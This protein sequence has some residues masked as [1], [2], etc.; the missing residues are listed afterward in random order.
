MALKTVPTGTVQASIGRRF[1]GKTL[2]DV[3]NEIELCGEPG[4]TN[5]VLTWI[6][7]EKLEGQI[8]LDLI[9]KVTMEMPFWINYSS[10]PKAE[11]DEWDRFYKALRY[12]E[13]AHH[14][15]AKREANTMYLTLRKEKTVANLRSVFQR[16]LNR[17]QRS[18]DAFDLKVDHGRKQTSPYG[19]TIIT[20]PKQSRT[21]SE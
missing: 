7:D 21:E 11:K 4:K 14:A 18:S 2:A 1:N 20:I 12:H 6:P 19:N 9:L 16:E 13:D 5:W 3:T 17:I 10:R 8:I 15:L